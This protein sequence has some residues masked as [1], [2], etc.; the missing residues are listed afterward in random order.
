MREKAAHGVWVYGVGVEGDQIV[1]PFALK[2]LEAKI[3]RLPRSANDI[4][5]VLPNDSHRIQL[6]LSDLRGAH[7]PTTFLTAGSEVLISHRFGAIATTLLLFGVF[8]T[9]LTWF[10]F[11]ILGLIGVFRDPNGWCWRSRLVKASAYCGVVHASLMTAAI[12]VLS[13]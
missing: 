4:L 3:G 2:E 13:L 8:V 11:V 5:A 9:I 12:I 10:G 7:P 1:D 6:E